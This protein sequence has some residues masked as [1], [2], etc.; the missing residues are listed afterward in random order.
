[1]CRM[2]D[3]ASDGAVACTYARLNCLEQPVPQD[4]TDYWA[5]PVSY[6]LAQGEQQKL[7]VTQ[8]NLLMNKAAGVRLY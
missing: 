6:F 1:M 4:M 8:N 7:T 2:T 5:D 3:D